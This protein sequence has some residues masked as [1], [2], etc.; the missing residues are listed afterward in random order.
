MELPSLSL[1]SDNVMPGFL[2]PLTPGHSPLKA[3]PIETPA[4]KATRRSAPASEPQQDQDPLPGP[5]IIL[6]LDTRTYQARVLAT[7]DE[8]RV[9]WLEANLALVKTVPSASAHELYPATLRESFGLSRGGQ[10]VL[11]A[12]TGPKGRKVMVLRIDAD[13]DYAGTWRHGMEFENCASASRELGF[14]YN[15]VLKSFVRGEDNL[16]VSTVRGV[17]FAY[18]DDY[19]AHLNAGVRVD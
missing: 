11:A 3:A 4:L 15:A 10:P 5:V 16:E 12:R 7:I 2:P 13:S 6:A 1:D 9:P 18:A 19:T 8:S 14:H 17:T